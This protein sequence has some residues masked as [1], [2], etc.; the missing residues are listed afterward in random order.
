MIKDKHMLMAETTI[1]GCVPSD[2]CG[3]NNVYMLV[4]NGEV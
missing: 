1:S 2:Y 4:L 3:V